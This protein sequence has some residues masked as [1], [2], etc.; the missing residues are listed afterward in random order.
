MS[1]SPW[2]RAFLSWASRQPVLGN[3]VLG[4]GLGLFQSP[5]PRRLCPRRHLC[6]LY[7]RNIHFSSTQH[8]HNFSTSAHQCSII[9]SRK[10]ECLHAISKSRVKIPGLLK[11]FPRTHHLVSLTFFSGHF[12]PRC[13]ICPNCSG[14][15][16]LGTVTLIQIKLPHACFKLEQ[17]L[18][19]PDAIPS[20]DQTFRCFK[21]LISSV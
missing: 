19:R 10:S 9:C 4:H 8:I 7:T 18:L 1:S 11:G 15:P 17:K 2:S 20:T 6:F 12:L 5:W 16:Q 3:S 21:K 13:F 14:G